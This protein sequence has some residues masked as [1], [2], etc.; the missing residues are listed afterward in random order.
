MKRTS[1]GAI[2]AAVA[3]GVPSLTLAEGVSV[4]IDIVDIASWDEF[5]DAP[6][7]VLTVDVAD[8]AGF[9]SGTGVVVT[10]IGYD[11]TIE[12]FMFSWLSEGEINFDD[13][14]GPLGGFS[15]IP[16]DGDDMAGTMN[17]TQSLTKFAPEDQLM[18]SMGLLRI[19]FYEGFD[20]L[21]D[22]IDSQWNGTIT[23]QIDLPSPGVSGLLAPV[24]I[25]MA[26]RRRSRSA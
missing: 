26:R 7:I 14:D 18:L 25:V 8:L 23:L 5:G 17:Y 21:P 20:D 12:T 13:A 15:I 2:L 6:N 24:G 4:D 1:C 9:G 22:V 3:L 11:L 19:E 10:G 16:G